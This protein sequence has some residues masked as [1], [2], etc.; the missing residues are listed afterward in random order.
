ME[1]QL[2]SQNFLFME[3]VVWVSDFKGRTF[4][5]KEKYLPIDQK[6][7]NDDDEKFDQSTNYGLAFAPM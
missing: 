1:E 3:M 5:L 4:N 2:V 7:S 6:C